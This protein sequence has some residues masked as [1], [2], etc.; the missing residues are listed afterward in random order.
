MRARNVRL[1][2][3]DLESS[4]LEGVFS[5]GDSAL[6]NAISLAWQKGC[7]FDGWR[8]TFKPQLWREVFQEAGLDPV[9]YA[10]R[11]FDDE[12]LLPWEVIDTGVSMEF[13]LSERL[14][15][16]R[17]ELTADC[18]LEGCTGCGVCESLGVRPVL[19]NKR[20]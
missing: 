6:G 10:M 15:S 7:R 5:R 20:E 9:A 16:V 14:K 11:R 12:E 19:G 8:E 18:T 3:H 17:G 13:L 4:F 1:K 2:F